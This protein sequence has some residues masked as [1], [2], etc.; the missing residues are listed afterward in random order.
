[1]HRLPVARRGIIHLWN[2]S[3][4]SYVKAI[5]NHGQI[6]G[7]SMITSSGYQHAFLW[8]HGDIFDLNDLYDGTGWLLSRANDI[9]DAGQITGQGIFNGLDHG[10]LLTPVDK[11][12]TRL[13]RIF[14]CLIEKV[15]QE[16]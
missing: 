11:K 6:V 1:V 2:G 9:N 12:T 8:E 4:Y 7:S 10:F 15:N 5:N 3:S 13:D 16:E 14:T